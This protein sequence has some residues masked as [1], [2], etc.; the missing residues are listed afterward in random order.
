MGL[1]GKKIKN[2]VLAKKKDYGYG[3]LVSLAREEC[4]ALRQ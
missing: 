1:I 2:T 4:E 3:S